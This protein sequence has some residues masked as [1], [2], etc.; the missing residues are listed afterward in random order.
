MSA[1]HPIQPEAVE[2][3]ERLAELGLSQRELAEALGIAENKISKVKKGE[4]RLQASELIRAQAWLRSRDPESP[5]GVDPDLPNPDPDIEYVP[6]EV[7]PTY[8][9]MGGG[10]TGDGDRQVALVPRALIVDILGGRPEDF[11]LINVRGDSMEP[12]FQHDDQLLID[13]RDISPAQPG[14]FAVWDGEWG[15]YVVKNVER[16]SNNEVRIF[17]SNPKYSAATVQSDQ[18]RI[19]GRPVWFGRKL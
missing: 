7:L 10:G 6:I 16:L 4:R 11:L 15:E 18:T 3:F 1:A 19:I 17:S 8:A 2:I 9:G 13:R 5:R 12:D 14:P